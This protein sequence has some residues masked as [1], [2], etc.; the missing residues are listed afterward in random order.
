[1]GIVFQNLNPLTDPDKFKNEMLLSSW[2]I[3]MH[4]SL[5]EVRTKYVH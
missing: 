1:M 4:T 3:G 5:T 2:M